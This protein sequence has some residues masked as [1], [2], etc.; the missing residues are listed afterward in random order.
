MAT[1]RLEALTSTLMR[2]APTPKMQWN[3]K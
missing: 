1:Q 3:Y 2:K